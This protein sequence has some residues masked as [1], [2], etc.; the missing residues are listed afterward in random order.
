MFI[1]K[2]QNEKIHSSL[3]NKINNKVTKIE[4]IN[5]IG[6]SPLGFFMRYNKDKKLFLT[7][8]E[9]DYLLKNDDL[10]KSLDNSWSILMTAIY[11]NKKQ[12]LNLSKTQ[13]DYL[14]QKSN[15]NHSNVQGWNALMFAFRY[16]VDSE[17]FLTVEQWDCLIKNT[18]LNHK[19]ENNWIALMHA[20]RYF[21]NGRLN[22]NKKQWDYLIMNSDVKL[23]NNYNNN[24]LHVFCEFVESGRHFSKE[25]IVY[26]INNTDFNAVSVNSN[27]I[28]M[29]LLE[30]KRRMEPE[31]YSTMLYLILKKSNL[32]YRNNNDENALMIAL[33]NH[34]LIEIEHLDFLLY[35]SNLKIENKQGENALWYFLKN[36]E[37]LPG[38]NLHLSYLLENV[39]LDFLIDEMTIIQFI[40]KKN[41]KVSLTKKAVHNMIYNN[42][43]NVLDSNGNNTFM[44][45]LKGYKT[46]FNEIL[47]DLQ[48][49]ALIII[50]SNLNIK[51]NKGETWED[52][53]DKI[54]D[55]NFVNHIKYLVNFKEEMFMDVIN[56]FNITQSTNILD[57][58]S[59][60][61]SELDSDL[62]LQIF[63]TRNDDD[64]INVNISDV[65]K[66]KNLIKVLKNNNVRWQ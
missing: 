3:L 6:I 31:L 51:N 55:K 49:W 13:W 9:W 16:N 36:Y 56:R 47:F 25:S 33:K 12:K 18:D 30:N 39:F 57:L 38:D 17:V 19:N 10:A 59:D 37:F 46:N 5:L 63:L 53:I 41:L 26:L 65:E 15:L 11:F 45:M 54:E 23:L 20:F 32:N 62:L 2:N 24:V 34:S 28:V 29:T 42:N 8:R 21:Q 61:I 52:L 50:K 14:I 4:D 7:E 1:F 60:G 40:L 48:N 22:L 43:Y 35:N 58:I 66:K 44:S 64:F 27:T